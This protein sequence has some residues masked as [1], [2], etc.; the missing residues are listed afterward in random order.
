MNWDSDNSSGFGPGD[1]V[2]G[3]P[4]PD[5][6]DVAAP[7]QTNLANAEP[8]E[9]RDRPDRK[10]RAAARVEYAPYLVKCE[11]GIGDAVRFL[12]PHLREW[13]LRQEP[14]RLAPAKELLEH[15]TL[16]V[17]RHRPVV[18]APCRPEAVKQRDGDL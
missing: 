11:R 3:N 9:G 1:R 12:Q 13:I 8:G 2:D 7:Q 17:R 4:P 6:I 5:Q 14:A 18:L 10:R 16:V 15:H